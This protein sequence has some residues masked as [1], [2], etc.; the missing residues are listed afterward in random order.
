MNEYSFS[1]MPPS[2][3]VFQPPAIPAKAS[4]ILDAALEAFCEHG[5]GN[6]PVPMVADRA[7]VAAGTIYRYFPGKKGV[8]NA[9]YQRSK[10]KLAGR[11]LEELP[12]GQP[13]RVVFGEIWKN[14]VGFAVESPTAF[15]FLETHHHADYLDS[16]SRRIGEELDES[17]ASIVRAWQATGEV[18]SGDPDT[19]VA[20]VYGAFVG[21]V[22]HR[23][24]RGIPLTEQLYEDTIKPAWAVL[25][26]PKGDT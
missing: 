16:E 14:L 8:V 19:L 24:E 15:L 1:T 2:P 26:K 9:L 23:S 13:A 12:L 7:G 21:V 5:F 18:R 25:A 22:R 11:L 3:H 20:F 17:I 10:S 4:A 6:T